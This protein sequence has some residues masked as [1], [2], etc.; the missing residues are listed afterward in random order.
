MISPGE[1]ICE[2]LLEFGVEQSELPTPRWTKL[3]T[4]A[5]VRE[6]MGSILEGLGGKVQE[7]AAQICDALG[8]QTL[9][10][11]GPSS[12]ELR[13]PRTRIIFGEKHPVIHLENGI[14]FIIDLEQTMFSAGNVSERIRM[15][16]TEASEEVIVDL[17]SGIGYYTLPLLVHGGA[18]TV[19]A[20]D[21]SEIALSMLKEGAQLNGVM[22]RIEIHHTDAR[23]MD[24]RLGKIAD[25][26]IL[27]LLPSGQ[28][29]LEAAIKVLKEEGGRLHLH[30]TVL[31]QP[32]QTL[33]EAIN[34][35]R[36]NI[37]NLIRDFDNRTISI[38]H[39]SSVKWWA[40]RRRHVVFDILIEG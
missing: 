7:C 32:E 4:A 25:R 3:G 19:H 27:G 15:G 5:V 36:D 17:F 38:E 21:L 23:S 8:I 37:T 28:V 16:L 34:E 29:A 30:D 24:E 11:R 6:D 13:R 12:G 22:E 10:I 40:R 14:Q 26:V 39:I 9:A 2:I 18:A 33:S 1:R 35:Q 31:V 20:C